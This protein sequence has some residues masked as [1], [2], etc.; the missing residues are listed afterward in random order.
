VSVFLLDV[1]A[2][3]ALAW[4]THRDHLRV[5]SWFS[6]NARQ[7][8]ATCPFT[9]CGFVRIVCNPAFSSD[10]LTVPEAVRLLALNVNHPT[11][12]FW[13]DNLPVEDAV[14]PFQ[15]RLVGHN[16]VTDGYLL[17]LAIHHKARLATL[18]ERLA[19]LLDP[20]G[21]ERDGVVVIPK[22]S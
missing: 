2:L 18:D 16:Q 22:S 1:S 3:I 21:G 5:Q 7:G 6:R 20:K 17:G 10:F 13:A 12:R 8:W 15:G 4:P 14:R 9:E 11:H 19:A